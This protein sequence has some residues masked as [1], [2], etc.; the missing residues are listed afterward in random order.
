MALSHTVYS[1]SRV[2][3]RA[4]AA[5]ESRLHSFPAIGQFPRMAPEC[6]GG[7]HRG[8]VGG[9]RV[10]EG[11]LRIGMAEQSADGEHGLA[12]P[13]C[14]AGMGVSQVVK[15]H[16]VQTRLGAEPPPEAVQP[17]AC[18]PAGRRADPETPSFR[19][20]QGHRVSFWPGPTA[21]RCG[22]RSSES[23]RKR[24]PSRYSD[25]RR[26]RISLLRHPVS[27]RRRTAATCRGCRPDHADSVRDSRRSSSSDRKRSRPLRRYRRMPRHGL[28][29]SG[30]R[31]IASA[32]FMMTERTG[33]DRSAATGVACREANQLRTSRRLMSAS[34]LP[35]K[36]GRI[37][38][39]R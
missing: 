37:C 34:C 35:A 23:R 30:R 36:R 11:G 26:V 8:G 39:L 17:V 15:P 33:I 38:F 14:E 13:Q 3:R 10:L 19:S 27:S 16:V 20:A 4:M 2:R 5:S 32:S 22:D 28:E 1:R 9:V 18:S 12:L 7:L 6:L 21:I 25:Q 31:P 24:W 29:P